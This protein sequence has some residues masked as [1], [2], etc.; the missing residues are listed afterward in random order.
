MNVR[1]DAG[2]SGGVVGALRPAERGEAGGAQAVDGRVDLGGAQVRKI[3]APA[4]RQIAAAAER[5]GAACAGFRDRTRIREC[6]DETV[7]VSGLRHTVSGI[8]P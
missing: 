6:R 5:S 1:R 7:V 2:V 4:A 8:M 3:A